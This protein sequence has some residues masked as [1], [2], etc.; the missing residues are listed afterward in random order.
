M[1]QFHFFLILNLLALSLAATQDHV[2]NKVSGDQTV[3]GIHLFEVHAPGGG[4]G[5]GVKS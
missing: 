2:G 4:I 5:L 3:G 1:Q